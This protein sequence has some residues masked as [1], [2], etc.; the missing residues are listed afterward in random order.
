[1]AYQHR[2]LSE[3]FV[4]FHIPGNAVHRLIY[5]LEHRRRKNVEVVKSI[6]TSSVKVS[7]TLMSFLK[8]WCTS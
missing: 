2:V 6:Y 7:C 4:S 3:A 5:I 1:M 8:R